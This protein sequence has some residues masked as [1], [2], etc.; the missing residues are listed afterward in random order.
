M[1]DLGVDGKEFKFFAMDGWLVVRAIL[2]VLWAENK[3]EFG[4]RRRYSPQ[5]I[6]RVCTKLQQVYLRVCDFGRFFFAS[7]QST[8]NW[9]RKVGQYAP[10]YISTVLLAVSGLVCWSCVLVCST[11]NNPKPFFWSHQYEGVEWG[12]PFW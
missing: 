7:F 1:R 10:C 4:E 11:R 5:G 12:W 6:A 2:V 3:T 9:A 8:K